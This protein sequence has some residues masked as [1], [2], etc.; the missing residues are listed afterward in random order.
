M[1]IR[2]DAKAYNVREAVET[3]VG[4]HYADMPMRRHERRSREAEGLVNVTKLLAKWITVCDGDDE[5]TIEIDTKAATCTVIE[6]TEDGA[7][8]APSPVPPGSLQS[9]ID[10]AKEMLRFEP[11]RPLGRIMDSPVATA[12]MLE[13]CVDHLEALQAQLAEM[14]GILAEMDAAN[15]LTLAPLGEYLAMI[16]RPDDGA[17]GGG[18]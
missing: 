1:K 10:Q 4:D 9:V 17:E 16:K 3:A 13:T 8:A 14:G 2:L 5:F 11:G 18:S 7:E 6:W 15:D 12:K